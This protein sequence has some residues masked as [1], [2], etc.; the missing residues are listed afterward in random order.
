VATLADPFTVGGAG[1]LGTLRDAFAACTTTHVVVFRRPGAPPAAEDVARLLG[2]CQ[3][4]T[5]AIASAACQHE[6]GSR[7]A[8]FMACDDGQLVARDLVPAVKDPDSL[9]AVLRT[10]VELDGAV[11]RRNA[12]LA[13]LDAMLA[14]GA[15]TLAALSAHLRRAGWMLAVCP[16]VIRS[17][18]ADSRR[19]DLSALRPP[20]LSSDPFHHPLLSLSP[21]TET[22]I[23]LP[24][25]AAKARIWYREGQNQTGATP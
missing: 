1:R 5:V 12:V 13:A 16:S 6:D 9:P 3:I 4:D 23:R 8:G 7:T 24:A 18:G 15:T 14:D 20:P 17:P 10:A 22:A 25:P 2:A 19:D 11:I 21:P